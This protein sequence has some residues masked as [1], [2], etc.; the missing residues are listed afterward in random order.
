MPRAGDPVAVH[1]REPAGADD[2][3]VVARDRLAPPRLVDP[4]LVAHL[5]RLADPVPPE[6]DQ[7]AG[8]IELRIDDGVL[9]QQAGHRSSPVVD[10]LAL[11]P[12][13]RPGPRRPR[14]APSA[15]VPRGV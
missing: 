5:D 1:E 6:G 3:E 12:R 2:L 9:A 10:A 4:P 11:I 7:P 13:P 8:D 14:R 15:S